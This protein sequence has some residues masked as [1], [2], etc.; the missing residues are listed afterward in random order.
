MGNI[1]GGGSMNPAGMMTGMMIGGAMGRQMMNMMNQMG[2]QV[3][4]SMNTPPPMPTSQYYIAVNGQQSGP[5]TIPQLQ[6]LVQQGQ[7]NASTLA[8]KQ[9]MAQWAAAGTVDEL[10]QLF[11]VATP[12]PMPPTL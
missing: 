4:Q 12:P 6:Q 5:F 8:W 9:G 1:G 7:I 11:V 10:A 3:Q 2:G